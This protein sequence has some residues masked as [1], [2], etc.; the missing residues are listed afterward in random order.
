MFKPPAV[1]QPCPPREVLQA[2]ER[3]PRMGPAVYNP[4]PSR[5]SIQAKMG[6]QTGTVAQLMQKKKSSV[7]KEKLTTAQHNWIVICTY[8][9]NER[10]V[11]KC[12]FD[13]GY[14]VNTAPQAII[15]AI[16][17]TKW[18]NEKIAHGKGGKGSKVRGGTN[19]EVQECKEAII[20]W[21]NANPA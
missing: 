20:Q 18:A 10:D 15:D 13:N 6:L 11:T 16:E 21:L 8:G 14:N 7:P 3:N 5:E 19:E 12:A 9:T 2:K 1:Y 17:S 4:C